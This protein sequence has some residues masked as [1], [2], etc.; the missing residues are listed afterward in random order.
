M[1]IAAFIFVAAVILF[2]ETLTSLPAIFSVIGSVLSILS[3][4]FIGFIIAFV[5]F[6]PDKKFE[7]LYKKSKTGSF[8]SAIMR[9][10]LPSSRCT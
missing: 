10:D 5:L 6:V 4:F 8:L 3:P 1:W 7:A 2:R 9:A